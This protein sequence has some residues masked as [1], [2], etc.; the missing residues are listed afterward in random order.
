MP[1][2]FATNALGLPTRDLPNKFVSSAPT[3]TVG[4]ARLQAIVHPAMHLQIGN[5]MQPLVDVSLLMG[6]MTMEPV[7]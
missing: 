5:W 2:V 4:P 1:Q 7:L 3:M 6:S